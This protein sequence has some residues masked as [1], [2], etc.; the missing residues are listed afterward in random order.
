MLKWSLDDGV[1]SLPRVTFK[2]WHFSFTLKIRVFVFVKDE[3]KLKTILKNK[4]SIGGTTILNLDP[5]VVHFHILNGGASNVYGLVY[6]QIQ[7]IKT[8]DRTLSEKKT[9]ENQK[10]FK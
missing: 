4:R 6:K 5:H 7:K 9:R 1:Q 10:D 8:K 2:S 3:C